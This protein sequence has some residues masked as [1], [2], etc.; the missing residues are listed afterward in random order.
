MSIF[1]RILALFF[2]LLWDNLAYTKRKMLRDFKHRPGNIR[3]LKAS[4]K[5]CLLASP[6]KAVQRGRVSR[7][8]F[9]P[10]SPSQVFGKQPKPSCWLE[11]GSNQLVL[12]LWSLCSIR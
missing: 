2:F 11:P 3:R 10:H 7:F 5:R 4:K 6:L 9:P 8:F 1:S 12:A